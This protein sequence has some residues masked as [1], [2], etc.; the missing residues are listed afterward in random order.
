MQPIVTEEEKKALI[1]KYMATASGR[2]KLAASMMQPLRT[3]LDYRKCPKCN[4][5]LGTRS[6][7]IVK[8]LDPLAFTLL[9]Q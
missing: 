4:I 6:R 5:D 2:T 8:D 9:L 1:S 3:T 7:R